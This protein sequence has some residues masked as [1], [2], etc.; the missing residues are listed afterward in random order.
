MKQILVF[1]GRRKSDGKIIEQP[2]PVEME[3]PS[4]APAIAAALLQKMFALTG[5]VGMDSDATDRVILIPAHSCDQIW[6]DIPSIILVDA[7][8]G[9]ELIRP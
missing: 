9:Q 4:H 7:L 2:Y 3:Q 6:C 8:E 5:V 1:K